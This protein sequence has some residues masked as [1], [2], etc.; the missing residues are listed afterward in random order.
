M[1]PTPAIP[2]TP[3]AALLLLWLCLATGCASTPALNYLDTAGPR[4]AGSYRPDTLQVDDPSSF[5]VASFNVK[6]AEEPLKAL[7]T[8]R[9]G[10]L[11]RADVLLL[12]EMD[13]L[14]TEAMAAAL[15]MEYVYYPATVHPFNDRPFGVAI[16]SPWPI[17]GDY[18]IVLPDFRDA[19]DPAAKVAA[20]A[21]VWVR[22]IPVGVI[23]AHLQ[24]GLSAEQTH[25][26]VQ[27]IVDCAFSGDCD[28]PAAPLLPPLE[29]VVL[30][31]DLNTSNAGKMRAADAVLTRAR[32]QRVPGTGRTY[33]YLFLGLGKLDH[34]YATPAL[35]VQDSGQVRGFFATGSDHYP[36]YA[37]LRLLG[38][39][40]EPWTGFES[41]RGFERR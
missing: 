10:G 28:H 41:Q 3:R 37:R 19:R 39:I 7:Q 40:P 33:K 8:L 12:Q 11:D 38:D 5:L 35:A 1:K 36:V 25:E 32:L 13:E 16:L 34:I 14:A 31:G 2:E 29:H 24:L 26:Q 23:N 9:K 21:V 4:F 17:R 27:T 15:G 22:G 18:K 30:A 6:L 20:A